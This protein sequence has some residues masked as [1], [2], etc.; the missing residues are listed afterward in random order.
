MARQAIAVIWAKPPGET[1]QIIGTDRSNGLWPT[2]VSLTANEWGP[3]TASFQLNRAAKTPWPDLQAFT[4]IQIEVG[5]VI[6]WGGRMWD[7]PS[8]DTG[9][10]A[11]INVT[12]R[13]WQY[14]LDDPLYTRRYLHTRLADWR[15]ARTFPAQNMNPAGGGHYYAGGVVSQ[16]SGAITLAVPVGSTILAGGRVGVTLDFGSAALAPAYVAVDVEGDTDNLRL[17]VRSCDAENEA[18]N[19]GTNISDLPGS[20][21]TVSG[22]VTRQGAITPRRYLNIFLFNPSTVSGGNLYVRIKAVRCY[23][24]TA[25][26]DGAGASALRASQVIADAVAQ[27]PLL[28]ADLTGIQTTSFVLPE[29]V[30]QGRQTP[31]Q[32]IQAVDA[33]QSWLPAVDATGRF[34]YKPRPTSAAFEVGEWSGSQLTDATSNAGDPLVNQ[35]VVQY[36]GPDGNQAEE[37]R[38]DTSTGNLVTRQGFIRSR[39][40]TVRSAITPASAQT[41]GDVWLAQHQRPAFKGSLTITAPGGARTM[42]GVPLHPSLMLLQPGAIARLMHQTDP[43]SGAMSRDVAIVSATYNHDTQ[44]ASLSL[45]NERDRLGTLL[46]RLAAVTS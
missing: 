1:W 24:Q 31:R 44:Q 36:T 21:L 34:T 5:G 33:Y 30:T 14:H 41:I 12:C 38:T 3:D 19:P 16:A 43:Q 27:C 40:I 8:S 35:V 18:G 10:T 4:P 23:W 6:V 2:G 26:Q 28:S 17:F 39:V 13:G 15:D 46:E 20:G 45:D 11:S 42:A 32:V 29:M 9:S 7:S 37:I 22:S 25:Y